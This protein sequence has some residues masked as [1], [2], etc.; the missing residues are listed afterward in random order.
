MTSHGC[1]VLKQIWLFLLLFLVLAVVL[2]WS[3]V[4]WVTASVPPSVQF[5]DDHYVYQEDPCV[6]ALR[7]AMERMEPF[8]ADAFIKK[9]DTWFVSQAFTDEEFAERVE[10]GVTWKDAKLQCW[11]H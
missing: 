8:I 6:E 7:G 11:R 2:F 9:D 5:Q 4:P 10:A 1:E 3:G